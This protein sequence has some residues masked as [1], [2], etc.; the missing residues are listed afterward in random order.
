[1]DGSNLRANSFQEGESDTNSVK[2]DKQENDIKH[3]EAE[4]LQ[5][6]LTRG[7]L[8]ILEVEVQ[9]NMDLFIGQGTSKEKHNDIYTLEKSWPLDAY[10]VLW[11]EGLSD[12]PLGPLDDGSLWRIA[13]AH[14]KNVPTRFSKMSHFIICHKVDDAF[15]VANH[16]FKEVVRLHG[17][18][19]T[20]V[21]NR[22][23]KFLKH[24]WRTLWCKLSTKLLFSTTC[25]P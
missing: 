5:G 11:M 14:I 22:D 7:R 8:K 3:N 16:F 19:K 4:A 23:L 10:E 13:R 25:H 15:H 2:Q 24:F 9:K 20:I 18:P 21:S 1:M 12:D 17:V 6:P